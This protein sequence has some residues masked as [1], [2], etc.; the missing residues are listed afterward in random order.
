MSVVRGMLS[1]FVAVMVPVLVKVGVAMAEE[2]AK[3]VPRLGPH[4]ETPGFV[5][6]VLIWPA[7]WALLC[8]YSLKPT[9]DHA[10]EAIR[11]RFITPSFSFAPVRSSS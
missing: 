5:S 3:Q 7:L 11:A 6:V 4:P 8:L 2:L 9:L 1:I 10:V